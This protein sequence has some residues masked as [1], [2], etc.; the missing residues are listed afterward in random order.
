ML[1]VAL[2]LGA[3]ACEPPTDP[4][5][6]PE[7]RLVVHAV[8]DAG[9]FGQ[10]VKVQYLDSE[11]GHELRHVPGASVTITAPDGAVFTAI[12][13]NVGTTED[14]G[15]T[16]IVAN[17]GTGV[18][19]ADAT[20]VI[21]GGT[22]LLRVVTPAGEEVTGSST[23]PAFDGIPTTATFRNFR[24]DRDTLRLNWRRI[25]L[26]ARYQVTIK[27]SEMADEDSFRSHTFFADTSIELAGTARSL[28]N[29]PL[30]APGGTTFLMVS[31]VDENY[32]AYYHPTVDPFAG[33]PPTRLVGAL[34][35]FGSA[36][37]LLY[38]GYFIQ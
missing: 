9:N 11:Q 24:S 37:T 25:P 23:V 6:T 21:P 29:R 2:S 31:A 34:G 4:I 14:R 15:A 27:G 12:E 28:D 32:F 3:S 19:G 1:L 13:V 38:E 10:Q 18:L 7:R 33:A 36:A 35:V 16:Y 17:L 20:P 22:Y 26:A 8:I 30:F 5:A